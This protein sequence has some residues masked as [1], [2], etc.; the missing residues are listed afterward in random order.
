MPN[1][2]DL[3][4]A[5]KSLMLNIIL[6]ND[7][8]QDIEPTLLL[9]FTNILDNIYMLCQLNNWER[10]ADSQGTCGHM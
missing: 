7:S 8:F 6:D 1:H 4:E 3:K 5:F 9:P 2:I 10:Q